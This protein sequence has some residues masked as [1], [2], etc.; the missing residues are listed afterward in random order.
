VIEVIFRPEAEEEVLQA[1]RWYEELHSG[2]GEEFLRCVEAVVE[3]ISR[4]PEAFATVHRNIRRGLTRRFPY[5]VF[6]IVEGEQAVVL[7]VFHGSRNPR[8][9]R[10]R[11]R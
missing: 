3:Q 5:G 1:Y 10:N 11:A 2:L 4:F 8:V 7:A 6:Y 9:W